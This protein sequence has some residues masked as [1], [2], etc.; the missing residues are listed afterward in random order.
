MSRTLGRIRRETGDQILVRSGRAML[1]TPYA[2]E[3]RDEVHQLVV[4]AQA[5]L[6]PAAEADVATLARTF[7]VQFNDVIAG[8]VLPRLTAR[9]AQVAPGVCIRVLG[10]G[11]TAADELRRGKTDLQVS[12]AAP[13][14][15]DIRA[16]RVVTDTLAVFGS[17]GL[18]SDPATLDGFAALPHVL[19][20][21][22]GR[23]RDPIDDLLESHGLRRRVVATVPT[24]AAATAVVAAGGLV[25]VAPERMTRCQI[26][27]SLRAYA[28]PLPVP[29]APAMMA[30]HARH[31][32]DSAHRWLRGL[33]AGILA[34]IPGADPDAGPGAGVLAP[35][36]GH[37]RPG[38]TRG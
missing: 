30:W 3:I 4:R 18:P 36:L 5:V 28:L 10:E 12:G 26:G 20:S 33:I 37:V 24:L 17:R 14:H 29:E 27:P 34:S 9:V 8:A 13:A 6:A 21:R 32:R 2:E 19:I 11:D 35:A 38:E 1:P 7:T 22:R 25:V 31:D 16:L 23:Q 15:P